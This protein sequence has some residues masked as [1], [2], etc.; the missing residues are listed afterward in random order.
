MI[1]GCLSL[2]N[3]NQTT[4][5]AFLLHFFPPQMEFYCVL[6]HSS[7]GFQEIWLQLCSLS[8]GPGNHIPC[9]RPGSTLSAGGLDMQGGE[10]REEALS[11]LVEVTLSVEIKQSLEEAS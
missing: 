1:S 2:A 6:P 4:Q 11:L 10:G 7:P 3:K 9:S 5:S 8:E